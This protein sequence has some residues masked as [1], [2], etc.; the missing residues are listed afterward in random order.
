MNNQILF[1]LLEEIRLQCRLARFAYDNLRT[2]LQALDVEKSFFYAH[3]VLV[4]ASHVTR[5]L[6]PAREASKDR[7][8][9]LR[10]ELKISS[11]SPLALRGLREHLDRPDEHFEDWLAAME[12]PDYV[13]LNIM[14]QGTISE[15]KQDRF[16][17]NLDP[18]TYKMVFRGDECDLRQLVNE[19]HRLDSTVQTWMRTHSP[20]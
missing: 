18:E 4:H 3:A 6:W 7:G 13:D 2:T 11:D 20:W 8:E 9:K 1:K 15:F 17:R 12:R 5:L 19:L 14:P 10:S 16:Q